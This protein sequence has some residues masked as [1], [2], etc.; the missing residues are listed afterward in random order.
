MFLTGLSVVTLH[1][2]TASRDESLREWDMLLSKMYGV[3]LSPFS[4]VLNESGAD[5]ERGKIIAHPGT[6]LLWVSWV[7]GG[8]L[9]SELVARSPCSR[10]ERGV[11]M[12]G[13]V[14]LLDGLRSILSPPVFG[15]GPVMEVWA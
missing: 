8:I 7:L 9:S 4:L 3:I 12:S 5:R 15:G 2:V 14:M 6:F 10:L 11:A 1:N 13:D